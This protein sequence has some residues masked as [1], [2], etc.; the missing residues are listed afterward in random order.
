MLADL[1]GAGDTLVDA[2]A[3][4]DAKLVR[5]GFG[6]PHHL[7]AQLARQRKA[8]QTGERRVRQRA[9]R[10]EAQITPQLEPDLAANVGD[11]GRLETG[12]RECRGDGLDPA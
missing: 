10:V 3:E 1:F 11:D 4:G 9:D 8:E 12:A 2:D 6:L 5:H 7:D